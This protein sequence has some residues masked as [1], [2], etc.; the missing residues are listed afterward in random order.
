MKKDDLRQACYKL[1]GLPPDFKGPILT[2]SQLSPRVHP[3][4]EKAFLME[5]GRMS[6]HYLNQRKTK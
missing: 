5:V 6:I 3:D 1:A 2:P 4:Q